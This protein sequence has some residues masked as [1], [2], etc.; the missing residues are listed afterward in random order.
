[1]E[2]NKKLALLID[3]NEEHSALTEKILRNQ[4]MDVARAVEASDALTLC[5]E[6]DP[7]IIFIDML[8]DHEDVVSKLTSLPKFKDI[9]IISLGPSSEGCLRDH[10]LE[11]GCSEHLSKP[12]I[13]SELVHL[14][15]RQLP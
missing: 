12:F 9:P 3:S 13:P 8:M 6:C 15:D 10:A 1:M 2:T 14:L 11:L 4:G 5:S 7:D